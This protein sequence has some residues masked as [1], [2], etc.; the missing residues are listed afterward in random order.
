M[1]KSPKIAIILVSIA[2]FLFAFSALAQTYNYTPMEKIPGSA[3]ATDFPSYL[4]AIYRFAIWTIGIAALLMIS[5]GGFMYFT[6]AGN[7]SHLGKAK[8]VIRDAIWGVVA[9]MVAYLLLYTINPDLISGR[10]DSL[11]G[12]AIDGA[13]LMQAGGGSNSVTIASSTIPASGNANEDFY[14][15]AKVTVGAEV[16]S[17]DSVV[18]SNCPAGFTCVWRPAPQN[19]VSIQHD[20]PSAGSY[21]LNVRVVYTD[22]DDVSKTVEQEVSFSVGSTS[23]DTCSIYPNV[24]N[25]INFSTLDETPLPSGCSGLSADFQS[26][27]DLTGIDVKVLKAIAA[28]ESTCGVNLQSGSTPPSCGLM[29]LQVDTAKNYDSDAV[30]C[31]WL[32]SNPVKSILIAAKYIKANAGTHGGENKK[33][34]AGYNSGYGSALTADGKKPAFYPSTDCP[35]S[36]AYECCINPGGLKETQGHVYKSTKYFNGQ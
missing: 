12:L 5:I 31:D 21:K 10:I 11:S 2:F 17:V 35:G 4:S 22:K 14:V 33:I 15:R 1:K 7:T 6:S 25:V 28:T 16:K 20:N 34:F 30:S 27:A 23:G 19:L 29:Q 13:A 26:A 32:K 3:I 18:I 36:L 24:D 8:D 9:V